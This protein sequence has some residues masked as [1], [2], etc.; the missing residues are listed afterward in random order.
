MK[1]KD[2]KDAALLQKSS[3]QLKLL[4]ESKEDRLKAAQLCQLASKCESSMKTIVNIHRHHAVITV[5]FRNSRN[6]FKGAFKTACITGC[7]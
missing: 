2:A 1:A 7:I 5:N 6:E 4:P 3:L